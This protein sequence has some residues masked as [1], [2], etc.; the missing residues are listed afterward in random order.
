MKKHAYLILAS[1][2]PKTLSLLL[3]QIDDERN[4]VFLH[5]DKKSK[6]I[7]LDIKLNKAN[8]YYIDRMKVYWG[9]FSQTMATMNLLK[10]SLKKNSYNYYHLI[11]GTTLCTKSQ[12]EIHSFFDNTDKEYFHIN[13][14]TFIDIQN[15]CKYYY[16]FIGCKNFRNSKLLKGLSMLLGKSQKLLGI[17]RLRKSTL[18]SLYNGME[19]FSITDDFARYVISKEY[20]IRK[21]FNHTL[22]SE[23][24]FIQS[25]AMHSSFRNK[26]YGYNGKDDFI[27]ASKTY[28]FW[29]SGKSTIITK[30]KVMEAINNKHSFFARKFDDLNLEAGKIVIK[31]TTK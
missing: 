14:G 7:P 4:D 1:S 26:V 24:V 13:V 20:L 25:L 8:L 10:V 28:Q 2:N 9:D 19:W 22:A 6:D 30:D 11:G 5:V 3:S 17:N 21:T 27:D 12:D 29:N 16:P 15:R 18:Y 23:E 31:E